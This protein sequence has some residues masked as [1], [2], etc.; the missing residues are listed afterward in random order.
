MVSQ[1]SS[2]VR[3]GDEIVNEDDARIF[4]PEILSLAC[5]GTFGQKIA[6]RLNPPQPDRLEG[7]PV[8]VA[9]CVKSKISANPANR[10][11]VY[12]HLPLAQTC[13]L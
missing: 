4:R 13:K 7:R 9:P 10:R 11:Q 2:I 12:V 1:G 6:V 5:S 8:C 3:G